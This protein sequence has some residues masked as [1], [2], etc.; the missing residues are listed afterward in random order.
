M[1]AKFIHN[2][3]AGDIPATADVIIIG[4]GP[5]GAAAAWALRRAQPDLAIVIV[6]RNPGLAAGASMASLENFRTC[7]AAPALARLMQRS[8]AVFEQAAELIGPEVHLGM[9]RQGYL[10]CGFSASDA[11]RLRS[12][13]EHLHSIGMPY[14]EYLEVDE[15][16]Q[17]YPW[18]GR[19]VIAAKYDPTA[20]WLDSNALI[21]GLARHADRVLTGLPD[22]RI[23]TDD[24]RVT[25]ANWSGGAIAA[26]VVVIAAGAGARAV[27]R[28][29]GVE[30]PLVVR[31]RQSMTVGR[32]HPEFPADAPMLIGAAPF[33]HVRPEARDGAIFG[34]EYHW[35]TRRVDG[36]G[37]SQEALTDPRDPVSQW[38]D[39]RFPSLVLH[40]LHRQFGG[41][42]GGEAGGFS[43][44]N[45]LRGIDHRAGYYTYRDATN[46]Y[47]TRP[48]GTRIPYDSQR[49]I[50]DAVPGVT[51][52]FA[53]VAHVGHG[54]MSAPAAG[55][56]LAA[57]VLGLPLPDPDFAAFGYDVPFID[58]DSGGISTATGDVD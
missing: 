15:I 36:S 16:R 46:A 13:V 48:D 18:I 17:R 9:K 24:G 45:Y 53:S 44:P 26:P 54:I 52:L 12:E 8:L 31:P 58:H 56:I 27:G 20:G 2:P 39:P 1:N 33:P 11:A 21:H 4:G 22:V 28:T 43:H 37:A 41:P 7:W 30:L 51:G 5:A 49:A 23:T 38:K 42:D 6:E 10:F 32:R 55:E 29:A 40:V 35:N 34:W 19:R 14:M 50:I 3:G 47:F 57:R 25:G